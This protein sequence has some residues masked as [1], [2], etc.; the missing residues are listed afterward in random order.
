M[1]E[2]ETAAVVPEPAP[3]TM[4]ERIEALESGTVAS[5]ESVAAST[6]LES[7]VTAV[8]GHVGSVVKLVEEL[9]SRLLKL[10]EAGDAVPAVEST[11]V[12][13]DSGL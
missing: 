3:V 2:E 11:S 6:A 1:S 10:E 4:V 7:R 5:P 9:A 8:E 12:P 13:L